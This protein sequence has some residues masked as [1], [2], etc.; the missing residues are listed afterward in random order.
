MSSSITFTFG[1]AYYLHRQTIARLSPDYSVRILGS[2]QL[3]RFFF[4]LNASTCK[5]TGFYNSEECT[6]NLQYFV[7]KVEVCSGRFNISSQHLTTINTPILELIWLVTRQ[8][9]IWPAAAWCPSESSS[10]I[11]ECMTLMKKAICLFETSV[12]ILS[13]EKA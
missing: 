7:G 11:L 10:P 8:Q 13:F 9:L 2:K 12:T 5:N 3:Q 6:F 1:E 4:K